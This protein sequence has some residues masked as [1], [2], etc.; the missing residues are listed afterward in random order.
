MAVTLHQVVRAEGLIPPFHQT[1]AC[2]NFLL[3]FAILEPFVLAVAL[4][5]VRCST[6]S[7]VSL[8]LKTHCV[9]EACT[10]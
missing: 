1:R 3:L 4:N 10:N 2:T 7:S 5:N 8:L 6:A 9:Q